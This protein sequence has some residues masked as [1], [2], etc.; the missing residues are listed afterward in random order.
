MSEMHGGDIY[1]NYV[2]LD[3]SVNVNPLGVPGSVKTAIQKAV[4]D[5]SAY[6]DIE[7][8]RLKRSVSRMQSVPAEHLILGNGSSELFLAV[9]HSINP[10]KTVIPIPSFLGYEYA[11]K[12]AEGEIIYYALREENGFC[13]TESFCESLTEDVDLL[14]L[15]NPNNPTGAL[16]HPPVL[17]QILAHCRELGIYVVLDECFIEFCDADCSMVSQLTEFD[18]LIL[19]RA[20]TKIFA[21]PGVRLGYLV[22][23]NKA[24]LRKI[25]ENIPEW[26][27]SCFAHAAGCA[28][29]LETAYIS[30]TA[31]YI[32]KE[33]KFLEKELGKRGCLVF[34]SAANFLLCYSKEPLYRKLLEHGILIR[35]CRNFRGLYEGFYRIAV[36]NRDENI[37]L[38]RVLD[39]IGT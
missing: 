20:F 29:A 22:C 9:V 33:R 13:V 36:R 38:M 30:Q 18:N 28:C 37:Q 2:S 25:R 10:K 27:L 4:E 23:S 21:I 8:E 39:E 34:P 26:N 6:P 17:K 24:L 31:G 7:A 35:D 16:I 19:I 1:R 11:A 5:C 14:F 32:K 12:A 3:F 15:A